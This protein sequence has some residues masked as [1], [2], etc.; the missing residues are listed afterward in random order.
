MEKVRGSSPLI[1]TIFDLIGGG[2]QF[3]PAAK[4]QDGPVHMAK[5]MW[6]GLER[7]LDMEKVRGSSPAVPTT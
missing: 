1:P 7:F 4:Q 2:V 3:P 5:A 6:R